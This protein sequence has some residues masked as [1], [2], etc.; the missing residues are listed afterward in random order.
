MQL[1]KNSEHTVTI[2]GYSSE[3]AG[4]ARIEG[5]VVF[6]P[7][8]IRDEVCK[9]KILKVNKNIAYGKL[10]SIEEAS[11]YRVEPE[12]KVYPKCG[13]CDFWHMSYDEE[14]RFKEAQVQN[15]IT[16]IGGLDLK[17]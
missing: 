3:G 4:V 7:G 12:C 17:V 2:T 11:P 10:I 16:R 13:G 6:I 9:I 15:V 14:L 1:V 8:V 5:Q